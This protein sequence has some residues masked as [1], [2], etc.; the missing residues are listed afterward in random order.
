MPLGLLAAIGVLILGLTDHLA[1]P[2]LAISAA[3]LAAVLALALGLE[4]TARRADRTLAEHELSQMR[5]RLSAQVKEVLKKSRNLEALISA[6]DEALLATDNAERVLLCNRSAEIILGGGEIRSELGAG[7]APRP[8]AGASSPLIGRPIAEVFTHA[9]LV[10]MHRRARAG[11]VVRGRVPLTTSLGKRVYQVSAGPVPVAWGEGVFG[12]VMVLR[13]VTELD[14]AVQV[15]TDLVA[16]ASHELRTPVA[17]IRAA[18]ETLRT[19]IHDDPGMAER[20]THMVVNHA[21]RLEEL[22]RD[23]LDLSRLESPDAPVSTAIVNIDALKASLLQLFDSGLQSKRLTLRFDIE[24]ELSDL[25]T[26]PKLLN[27]VL[28][29]LVENAVK[30]AFDNTEIFVAGS[31]VEAH[32]DPAGQVTR[33]IARFEVTDRGIGI[34]LQH[35]DRVFERFF[36]VDPARTGSS[37]RGTGLGLAIVKHAVKTLHGRVGLSSI[38]GQGTTV[39]IEI[40]VTFVPTEA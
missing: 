1:R 22:V 13:D 34:P 18:A 12:A 35:Q 14:Q 29:N 30:F 10:A 8:D 39:W 7:E 40:P 9:E 32:Q 4:R 27:L 38:W 36:Q 15:K 2:T 37:K 21:Q 24:P 16:N 3:I 11:E 5:A 23:L 19:A 6:M 17:A 20:L 26:D 33:G 31:L 25:H 28:R